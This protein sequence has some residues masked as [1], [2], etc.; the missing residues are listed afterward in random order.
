MKLRRYKMAKYKCK[1]CGH[2]Y[3]EDKGEPKSGIKPG[4]AWADVPA[5]W[6]CPKCGAAKVMFKLMR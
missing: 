4:T 3:D 2:I 1:T 5:D 6:E